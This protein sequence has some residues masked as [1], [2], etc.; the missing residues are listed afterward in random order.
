MTFQPAFLHKVKQVLTITLCWVV[1]NILM[2]LHNAVNYDPETR[3]HFLYFFFGNDPFKHLLITSIGPLIGGLVIG[4]FIVFFQREKLKGRNFGH[5]LMI[6][7]VLYFVFVTV[8]VILVGIIGAANNNTG[9]SSWA[10]FYNDVYSFRVLRLVIAWYVVVILTIFMLDVS[11][12]YGP[13]TL[14]KMLLGKFHTPGKE[15]RIFMF[16]DLRSSTTIA[17][18]MGDE[19]YFLL[20]RY[21]YQVANEAIINSH[22]EIYQYVGDEII[23]SWNYE[24]GIE[25][26]N[27]L[28]CFKAVN[29]IVQDNADTFKKDYKVI[30]KFK[31]GVH[32]GS[33][34]SG[35]I[36]TIKKDIVYSGD[37][38]NTTSRIVALC[39]DYK[40]T[41]IVSDVIYKA[42]KDAPG[43]KFTFLESPVLKGKTVETGLWGVEF[44]NSEL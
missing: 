32:A 38:L 30:P 12:R 29:K 19:Q 44:V 41:L 4:P 36:G 15:E 22:G 6:H 31:A 18:K 26:A 34:V 20:L 9:D 33:V 24:E 27:C 14:R 43:Y 8:C 13:A 2:E 3:K 25:N 21:F 5:K 40:Q 1:I 23:I 37:V 35:E 42:L 7:S 17:E 39:N 10:N 16:L 28:E 11:E